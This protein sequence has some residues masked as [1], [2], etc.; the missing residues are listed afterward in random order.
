MAAFSRK[1]DASRY[2]PDH[3]RTRPVYFKQRNLDP[4][5]DTS[6]HITNLLVF[7]KRAISTVHRE[8]NF[9]PIKFPKLEK[10]CKPTNETMAFFVPSQFSKDVNSSI[11]SFNSSN[12]LAEQLLDLEG[13]VFE[14][15]DVGADED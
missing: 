6:G 2:S 5:K 10:I 7:P 11:V 4:L 3:M 1:S 12:F 8:R 15:M 9:R 14:V 13:Q